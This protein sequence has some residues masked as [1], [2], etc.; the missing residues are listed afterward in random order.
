MAREYDSKNFVG[1]QNGKE[2]IQSQE[3]KIEPKTN[4]KVTDDIVT[5]EI[6][7]CIIDDSTQ[8]A[9][10]KHIA[11][12]T[13]SLFIPRKNK[14]TYFS[15]KE[16]NVSARTRIAFFSQQLSYYT[17]GR[18]YS[19][20]LAVTL[21]QY[22]DV[23]FITDCDPP[24]KEDFKDWGSQPEI[25]IDE[26]F[27]KDIK[28]NEFDQI[29][30]VPFKS[31][32]YAYKYSKKWKLPLTLLVF[33]TPNFILDYR[34]G[35]DASEKYW[36]GTLQ[37]AY[38][39]CNQIIACSK[40]SMEYA[41]KF[42]PE[43]KAKFE[44]LYPCV[45]EV[46]ANE[47]VWTCPEDKEGV[48]FSSRTI[49]FKS[50]VPVIREMVRQ[51]CKEPFHIIGKLWGMTKQ[52]IKEIKEKNPDVNIV[53]HEGI[54]DKEKFEIISKAKVVVVPSLFEGFGIP[55]LEAIY[56]GTR[57]VAYDLPVL[58]EVY[59][60]NIDFVEKENAKALASLAIKAVKNPAV[61]ICTPM[62][63]PLIIMKDYLLEL[64]P[65]KKLSVGM[66]VYN[67]VEYIKYALDSIYD[68]AHEIIIVEGKV[69][70]FPGENYKSDDGTL[71]EINEF[72]YKRDYFGKISIVRNNRC[73]RDKM[74]MQNEIAERATGDIYMK[75]DADEIWK[76][77][78]IRAILE[79]FEQDK[80]MTVLRVPFVHYW[81]NFTTEARDHG[82]KWSTLVPRFW[83]WNQS[84]RHKRTFNVFVDEAGNRVWEPRY[85]VVSLE[86]EETK[87][88]CYHFGYVKPLSKI[89]IKLKYY[90]TRGVEKFV[91]P[92]RY[93]DWKVLTDRTQPT[94]DTESFAADI[95]FDV[96]PEI[97]KDHPYAKIKDVRNV[98]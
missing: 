58:R 42:F 97:M 35:Q 93:E 77:D 95:D 71:E 28:E 4:I 19:Y 50:P 25:V 60:N 80:D 23:T 94:Q 31:A 61:P 66:I 26:N 46:V 81:T 29:I 52:G 96:L 1:R 9:L 32:E 89:N 91:D 2:L 73:W 24:F 90:A 64:I 36:T 33:E 10:R 27:A 85:K 39:N 51:G 49:E 41:K 38:L 5:L 37:E 72:G 63:I 87:I 83:R 55:P 18:Y 74:E 13:S 53:V 86:Q 30:A 76:K 69:N 56:M 11:L 78:D 44:Y 79:M 40:L 59:G 47:V 88:A 48:V 7:R 45:N 20:M 54:P 21:A 3:K 6:P 8:D 14:K 84:F 65:V 17:G 62:A 16:K 67:D 43:S 68:L 15:Y 98:K 92:K 57:V 75:V 22:A 34:E 70:G 82:G 12:L